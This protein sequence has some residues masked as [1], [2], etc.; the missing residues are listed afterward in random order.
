MELYCGNTNN[1]LFDNSICPLEI[2]RYDK[3]I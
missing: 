2:T 1:K 3:Y